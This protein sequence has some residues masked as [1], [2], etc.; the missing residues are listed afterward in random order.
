MRIVSLITALIVAAVLYGLVLERDRLLGF[1]RD[2]TPAALAGADTPEPESPVAEPVAEIAESPADALPEGTVRVMAHRSVAQVVDSSVALRG[3][4]EALRE[5]E[6][7]A[8]TSGKVISEPLRRGA[9]VEAGQLLCE[10]DPGTRQVT[11]RE[12]T[13]RLA[14]ARARLPE[15]KARLAEAEAALPTARARI[16]EAEAAVPAAQAQLSQARAGVPAAAARLTEAKARV[17]EAEAY[18]AEAKARVPE[19][20]A[21]LEEAESR[22][23]EA[24]ARLEE[25]QAAVPAAQSRLKEAQAAVP[26]ARAALAEAEARVP[27]AEARVLEAEA[28]VK[29]A[30][31]NLKAAQSLA[32]DGFAAQ[33]RLAASEA[34]FEAARAG[35]QAAQLGLKSAASGI[36]AAKSQVQGALAGV[37]TAK[38]QVETAKAAVQAAQSG[39]RNA[40]AGVIAAGAQIQNAKAGVQAA[41]SQIQNAKAGVQSATSDVEGASAAVESAL[42]GVEGAKATVI[43]AKSQLEGAA[44]A[45]QSAKTGEESAL[46]AIQAAEA[47]IASAEKE[48]ERLKI[49]APFA[50]L[51]ETDTAELGA[52]MQPGSAC[53]TVI[54]LNPVKIVGYVAESDVARVDHGAQAGARLVS[55]R[56]V[57]GK[58]TF[59]SRSAD[60]LTRTFRVEILVDNE[61]LSIRDGQTAE[62]AIAAEGAPAHLLAQS[63]LT[64]DD[65]GRLGVR[66]VS[67]EETV[68]FLPVTLLR[69]TREGVWVTGLPDTV[70]VITLGQEYVTDGVPVAPSFEE[71]IQ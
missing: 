16:L 30:D 64:L 26:A 9:L 40:K 11:L 3:E 13:A 55:G 41:Q 18:L 4:T 23:P 59:V 47:A 14:E 7:R 22:V 33:T 25:A 50:G 34:A 57:A 36:E 67:A 71:I 31:I 24:E 32:R 37:E 12:A 27:E 44:A 46:S 39:I 17:P 1:A 42:S 8:E 56:E 70:D 53:A 38:S 62:I 6:V 58:V 61:D 5:V 54:Q 48:I 45:V 69:D 65:D 52:L 68:A 29:E 66:S 35:V 19:V 21:R 20:E 43:S 60:P 28:R 10:I 2:N 63:S 49:H 15:S 51:L